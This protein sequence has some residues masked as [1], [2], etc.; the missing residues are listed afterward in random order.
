MNTT[1]ISQ[2]SDQARETMILAIDHAGFGNDGTLFQDVSEI[3]TWFDELLLTPIL[4]DPPIQLQV[5][6]VWNQNHWDQI[7]GSYVIEKA[8]DRLLL[9]R[10]I[11]ETSTLEITKQAMG[12]L[13]ADALFDPSM[14]LEKAN[15]MKLNLADNNPKPSDINEVEHISLYLIAKYIVDSKSQW[16]NQVIAILDS[17]NKVGKKHIR[18]QFIA[19]I[20]WI[21]VGK[22]IKP[23][24]KITNDNKVVYAKNLVEL[25]KV[26]EAHKTYATCVLNLFTQ[27]QGI[28]DK[29]PL[30]F[31]IL[32]ILAPAVAN[33]EGSCF[34]EIYQS[35]NGLSL[36]E[37]YD[38]LLSQ[39]G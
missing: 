16:G 35:V 18:R 3:I 8:I 22:K 21:I 14:Y 7:Y 2:M 25:S 6:S 30:S 38:Q 36:D 11:C 26:I 4:T 23:N 9:M 39:Y 10:K 29:L 37:N 28:T 31:H 12:K 34:N 20:F 15:Q 32:N 27:A 13:F 19:C 33:T 17:L 5:W 24:T 1:T